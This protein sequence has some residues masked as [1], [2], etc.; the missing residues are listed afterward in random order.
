MWIVL[1]F[2]LD[3]NRG[4]NKEIEEL[5]T[6][7]TCKPLEAEGVCVHFGWWHFHVACRNPPWIRATFEVLRHRN[8]IHL[9]RRWSTITNNFSRY[10]RVNQKKEFLPILQN[11]FLKTRL[12]DLEEITKNSTKLSLTFN[13][14][15][16]GIGKLRLLLHVEH[17]MKSLKK[18]GF[19]DKDIDEVKGIFSDTNLYLLCG[20]IF[21]GSVHVRPTTIQFRH[22]TRTFGY[23]IYILLFVRFSSIFYRL[24]TTLHFGA[25][26]SIMPAYQHARHFGEHLVKLSFSFIYS[27]RKLR[28]WY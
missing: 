20:T 5:E 22:V 8:E 9:L 13:Y 25:E 11:D 4:H 3:W 6:G 12:N 23:T 10:F 19:S 2:G 15:P 28:Y 24:K 27:T 16:I 21:I 1:C 26:R 7:E 14:S 18:I 17:A